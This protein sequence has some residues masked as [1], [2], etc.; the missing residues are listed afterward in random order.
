MQMT[1]EQLLEEIN[2]QS[3]A[4]FLQEAKKRGWLCPV[5]GNGSGRDGDGI[6]KNPKTGKYKCFKC[7]LGGDILDLVGAAYQLTDFPQ[8]LERAAQIYGYD[9]RD[10]APK[11]PALP[12]PAVSRQAVEAVDCSAYLERCRAAAGQTDFFARRGLSADT[13]ARFG[14]GFDP[15][16]SEGTGSHHWQAAIL[17]TS[18]ATYEARNTAVL[19]NDPQNGKNKY[20]KHGPAVVFNREVLAAET[21]QPIFVCEGIL[22]ALSILECGGQAVALGSAVNIPCC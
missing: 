12:S 15:D 1:K 18:N 21:D 20:R 13:V 2:R 22:D 19:P 11:A 5:C 9:L 3:P 7:G 4:A 16:F 10:T 8:R 14:L 17:P 6:V